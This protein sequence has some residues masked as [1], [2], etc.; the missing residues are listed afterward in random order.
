MTNGAAL[1]EGCVAANVL[2]SSNENMP[3]AVEQEN[4]VH[5][6]RRRVLSVDFSEDITA[7]EAEH[8]A[9]LIKP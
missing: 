7:E 3:I 8:E 9:L 4:L 6:L 5:S 2:D 1:L